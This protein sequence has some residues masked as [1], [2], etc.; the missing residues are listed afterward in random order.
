MNVEGVSSSATA[1][2][3][4]CERQWEMLTRMHC[5]PILSAISRV[6]PLR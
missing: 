3:V 2:A 5:I 6:P 4:A 1:N